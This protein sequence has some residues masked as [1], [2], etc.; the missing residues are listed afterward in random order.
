MESINKIVF[1]SVITCLLDIGE[2]ME[3]KGWIAIL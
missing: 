2:F 1:R 3:V